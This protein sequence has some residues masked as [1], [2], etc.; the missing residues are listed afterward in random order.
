MAKVLD[1][2]ENQKLKEIFTELGIHVS[3]ASKI[4]GPLSDD[5]VEYVQIRDNSN[6]NTSTF[7]RIIS[8]LLKLKLLPPDK[9][10]EPIDEE[11]K[12]NPL[13]WIKI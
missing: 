9:F 11:L 4:I 12:N 6:T 5:P 3:A 1:K 2:S 13:E 8:A 10:E 7:D